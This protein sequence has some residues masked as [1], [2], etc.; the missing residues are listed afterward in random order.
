M[1]GD[2]LLILPSLNL[3]LEEPRSLENVSSQSS[4]GGSATS[5]EELGIVISDLRVIPIHFYSSTLTLVVR[6]NETISTIKKLIAILYRL[7]LERAQLFVEGFPQQRLDD[8]MTLDLC[9]RPEFR[10]IV[11]IRI[12]IRRIGQ[13]PVGITFERNVK[14]SDITRK[15]IEDRTSVF[16]SV[17]PFER[18]SRPTFGISSPQL[19]FEGK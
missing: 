2:A 7:D 16:S 3:S 18:S 11:F 10:L 13:P 19:F 15:I 1:T 4:F 6:F 8:E 5:L 17:E 9:V 12:Y 14:V